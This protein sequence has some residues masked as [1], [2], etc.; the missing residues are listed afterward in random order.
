MLNPIT[1]IVNYGLPEKNDFELVPAWLAD[2]ER[3]IVVFLYEGRAHLSEA[4]LIRDGLYIEQCASITVGH[5]DQIDVALDY[6]VKLRSI[7]AWQFVA[8]DLLRE[9][10]YNYDFNFITEEAPTDEEAARHP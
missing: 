10:E 7:S 1:L 3:N 4:Q 6:I 2:D 8:T 9:Y 5:T